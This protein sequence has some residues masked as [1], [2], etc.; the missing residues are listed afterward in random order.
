MKWYPEIESVV[1]SAIK[2]FVGNKIDLRE[3]AAKNAKDPKSA[4]ITR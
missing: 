1:P 2:V 4:P 3:Q